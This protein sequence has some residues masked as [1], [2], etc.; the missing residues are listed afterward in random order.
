[1]AP[2]APA[3]QAP[4]TEAPAAAPVPVKPARPVEKAPAPAREGKVWVHA[5]ALN[6]ERADALVK[7]LKEKGYPT[8]LSPVAGK[9]DLFRIRIG[10]YSD[11]A[12]AE[13]VAKRLKAEKWQFKPEVRSVKP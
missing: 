12:K 13:A 5:A 4:A 7:K 8:D 9:D 11:R 6:A 2:T 10:P 3:A 1:M